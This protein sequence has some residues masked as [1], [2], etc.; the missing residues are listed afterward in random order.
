VVVGQPILRSVDSE[1]AGRVIEP[2]NYGS[3]GSRRRRNGGR[4]QQSAVAAERRGPAGVEEQGTFIVGSSR[5]L[6]GPIAS[7]DEPVLGIPVN[8]PW[9]GAVASCGCGSEA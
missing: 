6:G 2:R 7:V 3:R 8:N 9:P 4:Q 1:W 5:N